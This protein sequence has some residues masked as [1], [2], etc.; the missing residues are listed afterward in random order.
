MDIKY[1]DILKVI[2]IIIMIID[3]IGYYLMPDN[4][5]LRVIGRVA[6]PIFG[7][8]FMQ[9]L[10]RNKQENKGY[11][12]RQKQLIIA[13]IIYIV[14][15][16]L[17]GFNSYYLLF[18]NII[19]TFILMGWLYLN[20]E[21]WSV[22]LFAIAIQLLQFKLDSSLYFASII[23]YYQYPPKERY[24]FI[25]SLCFAISYYLF[26][27]FS[28]TQLILLIL[29]YYLSI[30]LWD[31]KDIGDKIKVSGWAYTLIR[32]PSK[33][34]LEVYYLHILALLGLQQLV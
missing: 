32:Y 9:G 30:K 27:S 6:M 26:P 11:I 17:A 23:F 10:E 4:L 31:Y 29:L 21:R 34:S 12:H 15:G 5:W 25:Y 8:L 19:I 3:H 18:S 24:L 13:T 22:V 14:V 2:G 16:L 33:Y 7:I 20:T 28:Y 1:R